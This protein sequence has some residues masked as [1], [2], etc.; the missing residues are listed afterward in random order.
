MVKAKKK[1]KRVKEDATHNMFVRGGFD[2]LL[3]GGFFA[4]V[5]QTLYTLISVETQLEDISYTLFIDIFDNVGLLFLFLCLILV[6]FYYLKKEE[7]FQKY[8]GSFL[9]A[10][11]ILSFPAVFYS[12]YMNISSLKE[13]TVTVQS[14]V[15][16]TLPFLA[17]NLT[18][19]YIL[20]GA[21][22]LGITFWGYRNKRQTASK[23]FMGGAVVGC[24][25][26]V[27]S[28]Y[29]LYET[30]KLY[31]EMY[32]QSRDIIISQVVFPASLS[33]ASWLLTLLGAL[34]FAASYTEIHV[35]MRR[36]AGRALTC[37]GIAGTFQEFLVL[38]LDAQ[39]I[40]SEITSVRQSIMDLTPYSTSFKN[41]PLTVE[42][43]RE[44]YV[45]KM[46]PLYM[47]HALWILVFAGIAA[48]GIYLWSK[49]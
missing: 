10:G 34:F 27:L 16:S 37:G 1:K 9:I 42:T 20:A 2:L 13:L 19:L 18:R 25:F 3:L 35:D 17:E 40:R 36:W 12:L 4:V 14:Y 15:A 29:S 45:K 44:F 11:S 39:A 41:L 49:K 24:V 23:F 33:Y 47:E 22:L 43:L 32:A 28:I 30:Y 5:F 31:M 38:S 46:I 8:A 6:C 26:V 48:F 21:L 7:L